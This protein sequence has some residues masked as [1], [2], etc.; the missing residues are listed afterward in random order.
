M[1][2]LKAFWIP[3]VPGIQLICRKGE[4]NQ[5]LLHQSGLVLFRKEK[6]S[7]VFPTNKSA[8]LSTRC[9]F[10]WTQISS[11][12]LLKAGCP[13]QDAKLQ[14]KSYQCLLQV[15]SYVICLTQQTPIS[16]IRASFFSIFSPEMQCIQQISQLLS[17]V[18]WTWVPRSTM[19]DC[20]DL[21]C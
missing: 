10:V 11:H 15:K 6:H 1:P 4:K 21:W 2:S 17:T 5:N 14:S 19:F 18:F 8:G 12:P 9:P 16:D 20:R 13:K 3:Y 7:V